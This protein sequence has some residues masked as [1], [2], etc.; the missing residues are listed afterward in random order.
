M[1]VRRQPM[2][3]TVILDPTTAMIGGAAIALFSAV[4]I[5]RRPAG[6]LAGSAGLGAGFGLIDGLSVGYLFFNYPDWM[7]AYL[8]DSKTVWVP[9]AYVV[10]LL[11]LALHGLVAALGV[12]AL[13]LH[14]KVGAAIG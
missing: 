9:L 13:V 3:A 1:L 2:L 14:R 8:L 10:F 12:G 7:F 5:Q 6:E 4:L 11:V